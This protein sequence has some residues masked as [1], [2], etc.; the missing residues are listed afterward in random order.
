MAARLE[1]LIR[2]ANWRAGLRSGDSE[3]L[4]SALQS[5]WHA[6]GRAVVIT[7]DNLRPRERCCSSL[8]RKRRAEE[9]DV[10]IHGIHVKIFVLWPA[11]GL[12]DTDLSES[13]L[14][15]NPIGLDN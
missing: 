1:V 9:S 14:R 3:G 2:I 12:D 7:S 11:L 13:G 4:T 5:G 8:G 10:D 6:G 15:S